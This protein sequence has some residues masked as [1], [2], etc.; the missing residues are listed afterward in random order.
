MPAD[1]EQALHITCACCGTS[2]SFSERTV[3]VDRHGCSYVCLMCASPRLNHS[4]TQ[5]CSEKSG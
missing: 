4:P 1:P 3:Y 2:I 5:P